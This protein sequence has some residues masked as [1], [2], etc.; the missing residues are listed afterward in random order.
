MKV[1]DEAYNDYILDGYTAVRA[2]DVE[3]ISTFNFRVLGGITAGF[4]NFRVLAHY[5][6][7]ITNMLNNLTE[8]DI[9]ELEDVKGNSSTLILGAVF[10]F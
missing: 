8:K 1:K 4:K 7:G 2:Q 10:Y 6:Y 9:P 3:D 5:Q